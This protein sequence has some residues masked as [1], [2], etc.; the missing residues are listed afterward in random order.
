MRVGHTIVPQKYMVWPVR[1]IA[2]AGRFLHAPMGYEAVEQAHGSRR[3]C[4]AVRQAI[5]N[6]PLQMRRFAPAVNLDPIRSDPLWLGE[7]GVELCEP[8]FGYAPAGDLVGEGPAKAGLRVA[9][10]RLGPTGRC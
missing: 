3:G 4:A 6:G 8:P 7:T 9:E 2:R 5:G 1:V 10:L